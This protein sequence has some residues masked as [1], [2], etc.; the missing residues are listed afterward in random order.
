MTFTSSPMLWAFKGPQGNAL[1]A[2]SHLAARLEGAADTGFWG[3][4]WNQSLCSPRNSKDS[5][6]LPLPTLEPT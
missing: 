1:V 3:Y 4:P 6:T 5:G 2:I